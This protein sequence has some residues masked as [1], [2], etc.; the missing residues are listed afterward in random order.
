MVF[1]PASSFDLS[2]IFD[3]QHEVHAAVVGF[4]VDMGKLTSNHKGS[5]VSWHTIAQDQGT[6]SRN[7]YPAVFIV[8]VWKRKAP[9]MQGLNDIVWSVLCQLR[10]RE[11]AERLGRWSKTGRE[12]E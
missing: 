8:D 4:G 7:G 12:A 11:L 10:V 9:E 2:H 5:L 6:R 3:R 1:A